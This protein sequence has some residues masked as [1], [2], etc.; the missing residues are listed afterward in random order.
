MALEIRWGFRMIMLVAGSGLL[1][2]LALT[3]LCAF[4]CCWPK[5]GKSRLHTP[6]QKGKK[7]IKTS[8]DIGKI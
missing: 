1:F 7:H 6:K 8:R 3:I 4:C 2:L 5:G